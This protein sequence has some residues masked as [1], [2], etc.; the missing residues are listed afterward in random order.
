MRRIIT[1]QTRTKEESPSDLFEAVMAGKLAEVKRFVQSGAKIDQRKGDTTALMFAAL[2]GN[3][4]I[5]EYLIRQGADVNLRNDIGQTT[6]M[7]AAL[8]GHK[9]IIEQLMLAGA[10]VRAVDYDNR[11][12]VAWAA[13]R[14]DFPD[15]ISLLVVVGADYNARDAAG[16]TPLMLAALLGYADSVGILLTVGADEKVKFRGKTA[17]EMAFERG[18]EEVCKTMKA[19]LKNRPKGHA[20]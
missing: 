11:N 19:I 9:P 2:Q 3:A 14:G 10:D 17:Y 4:Q 18:H 7:I 15:V 1:K 16:L 6:L 8:G 5:T 12:A 13:S 20:L